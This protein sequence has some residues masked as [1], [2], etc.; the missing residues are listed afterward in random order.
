[1][2]ISINPSRPAGSGSY[3]ASASE[4]PPLP[5]PTNSLDNHDY[6]SLLDSLQGRAQPDTHWH[7]FSIKDKNIDDFSSLVAELDKAYPDK[8]WSSV[9]I[10]LN[11]VTTFLRNSE[12]AG[13]SGIRFILPKEAGKSYEKELPQD[14]LLETWVTYDAQLHDLFFQRLLSHFGTEI[15]SEQKPELDAHI[16]GSFSHTAHQA[17][18]NELRIGGARIQVQPTEKSARAELA[19][20]PSDPP[21]PLEF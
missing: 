5:R 4:F 12:G 19:S 17:A 10:T 8:G 7:E 15:S 20:K 3:S 13:P 21:G 9:A 14:V 18:V 6:H 2:G 16:H 11:G 1:M